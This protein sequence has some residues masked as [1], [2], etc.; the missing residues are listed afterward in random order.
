MAIEAHKA[1]NWLD[2]SYLAKG[3]ARMQDLAVNTKKSR[4]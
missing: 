4:C 1:K 2:Q 3:K